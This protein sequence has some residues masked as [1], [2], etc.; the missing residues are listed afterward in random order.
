MA[1]SEASSYNEISR[2]RICWKGATRLLR[3]VAV[4][5]VLLEAN[6]D[7]LQAVRF[8]LFGARSGG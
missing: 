8:W 2:F 5:A 1:P 7:G 4:R 6:N 3:R